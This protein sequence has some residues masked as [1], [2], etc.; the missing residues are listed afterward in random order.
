MSTLMSYDP[1]SGC[2]RSTRQGVRNPDWHH[3]Q[4]NQCQVQRPH[5]HDEWHSKGGGNGSR[6]RKSPRYPMYLLQVTEPISHRR[7]LVFDFRIYTT[8]KLHISY[9]PNAIYR[10]RNALHTSCTAQQYDS[11]GRTAATSHNFR[12]HVCFGSLFDRVV[13]AS[14][15]KKLL[16]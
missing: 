7:E 8:N 13:S 9:L 5:V 4:L 3:R 15:H 10:E 6:E 2:G 11:L 1:S 12:L 14:F 16:L